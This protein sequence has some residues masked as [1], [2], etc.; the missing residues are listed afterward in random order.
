MRHAHHAD[1]VVSRDRHQLT[2]LRRELAAAGRA[3][4]FQLTALIIGGAVILGGI[5]FGLWWVFS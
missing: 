3:E 5:L 4:A 2:A 1:G